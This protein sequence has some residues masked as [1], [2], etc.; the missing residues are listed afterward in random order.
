MDHSASPLP[1][2]TALLQ[3]WGQG[4][5]QALERLLPLVYNELHRRARNYWVREHAGQTLQPTALVHEAFLRLV[6]VKGVRWQDRA[7]FFA[8]SAQIMRRIF[9]VRCLRSCSPQ[10]SRFSV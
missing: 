8:F 3:A 7:H 6:D 10:S 5:Q 9:M 4:D 1:P 2:V